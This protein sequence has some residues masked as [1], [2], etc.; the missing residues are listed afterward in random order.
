[1]NRRPFQLENE[2]REEFADIMLKALKDEAG[3]YPTEQDYYKLKE[4]FMDALQGHITI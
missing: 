3:F 2:L 4:K 1:M